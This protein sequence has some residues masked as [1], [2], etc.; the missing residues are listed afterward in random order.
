MWTR[1]IFDLLACERT[2]EIIILILQQYLNTIRYIMHRCCFCGNERRSFLSLT[3]THSLPIHHLSRRYL[4]TLCLGKLKM[5]YL[6]STN[7]SFVCN[8]DSALF[9]GNTCSIYGLKL[10][11]YQPSSSSVN[12]SGRLTDLTIIKKEEIASEYTRYI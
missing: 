9:L 6:Y 5:K 11:T 10:S 12:R 1:C 7:A 2:S 8:Q 3:L 4:F